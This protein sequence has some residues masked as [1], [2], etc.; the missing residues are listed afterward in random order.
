MQKANNQNY[1]Y[2]EQ[3][4]R[5]QVLSPVNK[6]SAFINGAPESCVAPSAEDKA[7]S[8]IYEPE[9][10]FSSYFFVNVQTFLEMDE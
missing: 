2:W 5:I 8:V 10:G 4:V 9:I 7:K 6:V 3:A 1:G